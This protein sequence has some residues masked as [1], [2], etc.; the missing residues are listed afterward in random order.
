LAE[1]RSVAEATSM[2]P[3]RSQVVALGVL[4]ASASCACL[5]RVFIGPLLAIWVA[6]PALFML[7]VAVYGHLITFDDDFPGGWS[8]QDGSWKYFRHSLY[9]L[10]GKAA[11]LAG[12]LAV[13]LL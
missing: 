11:F 1:E 10:L 6:V 12:L 9:E 7:G 5:T 8:N 13:L 2:A 4:L 3:S